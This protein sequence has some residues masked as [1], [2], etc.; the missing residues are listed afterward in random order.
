MADK[1]I[2]E[3]DGIQGADGAHRPLVIHES[4]H[5]WTGAQG[6]GIAQ[7]VDPAELGR[8]EEGLETVERCSDGEAEIQLA[9]ITALVHEQMGVLLGQQVFKRTDLAHQGKEVGVVEE[10][11]MQPHLDV[12][13]AVIH[14][15]ANLAAPERTRF[16]E[17]NGMAC[18]DQI[19]RSREAGETGTDNR[20]PHHQL[21]NWGDSMYE[22]P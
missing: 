18:I 6:Q 7:L 22:A 21:C 20:D 13:A 1:P 17:V 15:A 9:Q 10:K 12:V 19:H 11:D 8:R 4:P 5:D 3:T 2:L 16:V 14:P